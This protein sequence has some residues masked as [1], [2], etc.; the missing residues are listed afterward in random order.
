[1]LS[2][3]WACRMLWVY[4]SWLCSSNVWLCTLRPGEAAG[5]GVTDN[6]SS[7]QEQLGPSQ[8]PGMRLLAGQNWTVMFC[9]QAAVEAWLASP[10][11]INHAS[12]FAFCLVSIQHQNGCSPWGQR[13]LW[14]PQSESPL[15]S[16]RG[17][18]LLGFLGQSGVTWVSWWKRRWQW[19]IFLNTDKLWCCLP[20]FLPSFLPFIL[21]LFHAGA[22]R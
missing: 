8:S 5:G 4:L 22:Q 14:E 10:H 16:C 11:F 2:E 3:S 20:C 19:G 13:H 12:I 15:S 21:P 18:F 7:W 17:L 1:M 6:I 9:S